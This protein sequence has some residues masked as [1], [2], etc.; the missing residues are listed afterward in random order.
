MA[1]E[2]I[3][4]NI[5]T[6]DENPDMLSFT[7]TPANVAYANTLRR[8]VL[9]GVESVAFR[10]DMNEKGQTSDVTVRENTTPMTN[11][12]LADRIGLIP[13]H[14][15]PDTWNPEDY[16][17]ELKVEN[18]TENSLPV[19]A[20][21]FEI[22]KRGQ[23]VNE[24]V[25]ALVGNKEFFHP[26]RVSKDTSLIAVLKGKQPSQTGQKIHLVAKATV[27]TGRD[28]IRFSPVSQCSYGYSIDT[29]EVKQQMQFEKWLRNSKNKKLDDLKEGRAANG[30]S[31]EEVFKREFQTMEVQRCYKVDE[32][33]GEPNSFD[34]V[35][36]SVGVQPVA[37]IIEKALLNIEKK[38]MKYAA[39]DKEAPETVRVQNADARMKGFDFIFQHEDHTLGNLLQTYMDEH[40]MGTEI[41]FV[42]YK[43]PHPLRD[44]MVIRVGVDFPL[45]PE[46]DGKETVA[47]TAVAKAANECAMMFRKWREDWLRAIANGQGRRN[48][49]S[50]RLTAENAKA[51]EQSASIARQV[52]P[53]SSTVAT[54]RKRLG[55]KA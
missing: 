42:G 26:D 12:M 48:L 23:G 17:F 45:N 7:L 27:G 8:T 24:D 38:C 47:R 36:E 52:A 1:A 34:F 46:L 28:H 19:R 11:E 44:E 10:S 13:I 50:L 5:S 39:L 4:K 14:A 15:D 33:T 32:L 20:E 25:N 21:D 41:T 2:N 31:L 29:D 6:I 35:V 43:V 16:I 51:T 49:Q 22:R 3:F 18:T 53:Q 40:M 9:T 55:T 37:K 54:A 30:E